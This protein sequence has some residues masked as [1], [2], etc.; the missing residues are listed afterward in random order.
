LTHP[1]NEPQHIDLDHAL[2]EELMKDLP[3]AKLRHE[4]LPPVA[5]AAPPPADPKAG[6]GGQ[7]WGPSSL[8]PPISAQIDCIHDDAQRL[9]DT[10]IDMQKALAVIRGRL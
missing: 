7:K 8:T 6:A 9:I 2:N 1:I 3:G 10:L 5:P 4:R